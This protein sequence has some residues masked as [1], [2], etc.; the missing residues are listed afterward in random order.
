ML[1]V[2]AKA[3]VDATYLSGNLLLALMQLLI[4]LSLGSSDCSFNLHVMRF[5]LL[6]NAVCNS[7]QVGPVLLQEGDSTP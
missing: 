4:R 6:H 1:T 3:S 5:S 2:N 7:G